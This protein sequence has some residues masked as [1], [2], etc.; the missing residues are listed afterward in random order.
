MMPFVDQVR[1]KLPLPSSRHCAGGRPGASHGI[2]THLAGHRVGLRSCLA[3]RPEKREYSYSFRTICG[4]SVKRWSASWH[5]RAQRPSA[6]GKCRQRTCRFTPVA[7]TPQS[8]DSRRRKSEAGRH[9]LAGSTCEGLKGGARR[10]EAVCAIPWLPSPS[11]GSLH[12]G[13]LVWLSL[14]QSPYPPSPLAA[15]QDRSISSS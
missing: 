4:M 6:L 15:S 2:V 5:G 1:S 13:E 11:T 10:G 9:A 3:E 14:D 8:V 7:R 12:T